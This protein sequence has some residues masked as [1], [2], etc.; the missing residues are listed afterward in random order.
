M[1]KIIQ[2]LVLEGDLP[3]ETPDELANTLAKL[4]VESDIIIIGLTA[5]SMPI[6]APAEVSNV[7]NN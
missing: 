1:V 4:G 5:D 6:L 7:S 3:K 2:I